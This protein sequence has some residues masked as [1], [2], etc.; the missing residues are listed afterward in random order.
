M[1]E[2]NTALVIANGFDALGGALAE[3]LYARMKTVVDRAVAQY[4]PE[5]G[6]IVYN[7]T[8]V[9]FAR[10]YG[11]LPKACQAYRAKTKGKVERPF[12]YIDEDFFLGRSFR[13]RDDLNGQFRQWLDQVANVWVHATRHRVVACILLR[14][15]TTYSRCRLDR[16]RLCCTSKAYDRA[17]PELMLLTKPLDQFHFGFSIHAKSPRKLG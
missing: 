12:R 16:F 2:P 17:D 4:G 10:H 13:N 5:S 11:Y 9:E 7:R 3:I 15:A 6:H 1:R 14:S 8:P